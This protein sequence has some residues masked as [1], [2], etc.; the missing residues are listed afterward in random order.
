MI[1]G[2]RRRGVSNTR[3]FAESTGTETIG[4]PVPEALAKTCTFLSNTPAANKEYI[5]SRGALQVAIQVD[6]RDGHHRRVGRPSAV[7]DGVREGVSAEKAWIWCVQHV[8]HLRRFRRFR[9][10]PAMAAVT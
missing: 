8:N 3:G 5:V 7:G 2:R 9:R 6:N 10:R 1:G 4:V